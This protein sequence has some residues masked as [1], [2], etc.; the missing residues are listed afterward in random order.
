MKDRLATKLRESVI[1]IRIGAMLMIVLFLLVNV[2]AGRTLEAG[3]QKGDRFEKEIRPI[4]VEHCYEC[5]SEESGK[6]KGELRLDS[7]A[8]LLTGGESGKVLVPGSSE[9]SRI[10]QLI[11]HREPEERMPPDYRLP[12]SLIKKIRLWIDGGLDLPDVDNNELEDVQKAK[13]SPYPPEWESHWAYQPVTNPTPPEVDGNF[14]IR[15]P[16]DQF[17]L[18]KLRDNGL[19]PSPASDW[20]RLIRRLHLDI[21]GLPPEK[22]NIEEFLA[23]PTQ[24]KYDAM[25]DNL[26]ASDAFGE[27]WAR[28]WLDVARYA[29]S[30]GSDENLFLGNAY[31]YRNYVIESFNK[32]KSYFQFIEEQVAGDLLAAQTDKNIYSAD[33]VIATGFLNLGPKLVAEQD[34]EKLRMDIVDEQMDVLGQAFLATSIGCAR[35]HDHKFDPFSHED[36]YAMAGIFRSTRAMK[37]YDHVSHWHESLLE[38]PQLTKAREGAKKKSTQL[39]SRLKGLRTKAKSTLV[40]NLRRKLAEAATHVFTPSGLQPEIQEPLL[41]HATEKWKQLIAKINAPENSHWKFFLARHNFHFPAKNNSAATPGDITNFLDDFES[42]AHAPQERQY[43]RDGIIGSALKSGKSSFLDVP[44]A[45]IKESPVMTIAAWIWM[46]AYPE[47]NDKRRWVLSK[48]ENEHTDAHIAI[49]VHGD[50]PLAYLNVGGNPENVISLTGKRRSLKLGKWHHLALSVGSNRM[51]LFLDATRVGSSSLES[52]RTTGTGH[53]SVGKRPDGFT[54]FDGRIDEPTIFDKALSQEE[55]KMLKNNPGN[56][57]S[58]PGLIWHESFDLPD[59]QLLN[60]THLKAIREEMAA[61]TGLFS[62]PDSHE[63][64]FPEETLGEIVGLESELK[65]VKAGMTPEPGMAVSVIEGEPV[66]LPIHVRGNH[67]IHK[68]EPLPRRTPMNHMGQFGIKMNPGSS[69]RREL[70]QWISH[71]DNPLSARVFVNRLWA[72][73]LGR[74]IVSTP[75]NFGRRGSEPSHPELLDWL[76]SRLH[77]SN[78]SMKDILRLI[79]TSATYMQDSRPESMKLQKDPENKFLW[80][81][82]PRRMTAEQIRDSLLAVSGKLELKTNKKPVDV[83]NYSYVPRSQI[84]DEALASGRRTIYL[85]VIRDRVYAEL[86]IFDF[87]NPGVSSGFRQETTVPLQA[88]YFLNNKDVAQWA[89]RTVTLALN[90]KDPIGFLIWRVYSRPPY[91]REWAWMNKIWVGQ[92]DSDI[93]SSLTEL[94][95]ALF[96]SN[97]FVFRF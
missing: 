51:D 5:H 55:V 40:Q 57:V 42:L 91:P 85:P 94:V 36:Y 58:I 86:E 11:S 96:A 39:E 38:H 92:S 37:N 28:M 78:G 84:F 88:L 49:G 62:L 15:N 71:R 65:K 93:K 67:M 20:N 79:F 80:R 34:K 1:R 46:D 70:A 74:G 97:E 3:I 76:A 22:K 2:G 69:G 59:E 21:T 56:G 24:E 18:A 19:S 16:I 7:V 44:D 72:G 54:Y 8:G 41:I 64:F 89:E 17:V 23:E 26:L 75:N 95:L 60:F 31:R 25:V 14:E 27:H 13:N 48:N 30:N 81:V 6:S 63:E 32:D 43:A 82:T 66:D 73:A 61:S 52:K 83:K 33:A 77:H 50:R 87:A 4:L 90:Q 29:D 12:E 68:G 45:A 47:G 10:F 35:C 53:V 9:S